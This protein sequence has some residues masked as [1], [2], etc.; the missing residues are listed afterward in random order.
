MLL[1]EMKVIL[2]FQLNMAPFWAFPSDKIAR[3][4]SGLFF[5]VS[6][7]VVFIWGDGFVIF[8]KGKYT[9]FTF[10]AQFIK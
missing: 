8:F 3:I 10:N 7:V 6:F 1:A 4:V 9:Q 5:I 2:F